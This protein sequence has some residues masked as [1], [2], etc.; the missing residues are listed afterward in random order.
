[1]RNI[2]SGGGKES[3]RLAEP[4]MPTDEESELRVLRT[5]VEEVKSGILL[6]DE[7]ALEHL[8][9]YRWRELA[10]DAATLPINEAIQVK[11]DSS[12]VRIETIPEGFVLLTKTMGGMTEK[13]LAITL[14]AERG[15][16]YSTVEVFLDTPEDFFAVN[17]SQVLEMTMTAAPGLKMGESIN[18]NHVAGQMAAGKNRLLIG[19]D[20]MASLALRRGRDLQYKD[21]ITRHKQG[22]LY[23]S[24]SPYYV[25]SDRAYAPSIVF[26][27]SD[28]RVESVGKDEFLSRKPI[29][30]AGIKGDMIALTNKITRAFQPVKPV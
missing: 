24:Y 2:F 21:N 15:L 1:M 16:K 9:T 28:A 25:Q 6:R 30:D 26:E 4:R 14:G 23:G 10:H 18:G 20:G 22:I 8:L 29:F 19:T 7:N 13:D 11:M 5:E 27:V 12:D 3:P 17:F